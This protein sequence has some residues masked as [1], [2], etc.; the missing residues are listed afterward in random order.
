MSETETLKKYRMMPYKRRVEKVTDEREG[1][2]FV[3]RYVDLPGLAADGETRA[4]A[5]KNAEAAFDDY[6][7]ARLHFG[8]PIPE[9]E[10]ARRV[11]RAVALAENAPQTTLAFQ[12]V[13]ERPTMA[14]AEGAKR[15][16]DALLTKHEPVTTPTDAPMRIQQERIA[17]VQ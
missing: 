8:D 2:Y 4:E 1:T 3:C 6:I 7:L 12:F 5:V 15:T 16:L 9:P 11:E 10:G 14:M 17:I 13:L